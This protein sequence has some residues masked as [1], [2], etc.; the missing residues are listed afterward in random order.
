LPI[1]TVKFQGSKNLSNAHKPPSFFI[2]KRKNILA[3]IEKNFL[4]KNHLPF[5]IKTSSEFEQVFFLTLQGSNFIKIAQ[6]AKSATGKMYKRGT[7]GHL[8]LHSGVV[9][10]EIWKEIDY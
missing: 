4:S 6:V 9:L 8:A 10:G 2:L 5:Q 7:F 3:H 1:Y